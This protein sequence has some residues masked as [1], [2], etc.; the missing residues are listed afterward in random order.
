MWTG[1]GESSQFHRPKNG[2]PKTGE[3]FERA[4]PAKKERREERSGSA[5][6]ILINGLH[7][8]G[9]KTVPICQHRLFASVYLFVG[10]DC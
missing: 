10:I 2:R 8:D 9:K 5:G 3:T 6:I 4:G 1:E 7:C